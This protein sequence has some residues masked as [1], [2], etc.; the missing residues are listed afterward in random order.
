MAKMA[1]HKLTLLGAKHLLKGGHIKKSTHTKMVKAAKGMKVPQAE[2]MEPPEG[3][4]E[5][6]LQ[7]GSLNPMADAAT[8]PMSLAGPGMAPPAPMGMLGGS[9]PLLR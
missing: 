5:E 9:L 2:P 7:F 8:A 6:P 4:G 3:L 1:M